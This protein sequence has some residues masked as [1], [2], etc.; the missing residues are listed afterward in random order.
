MVDS[1]STCP[2]SKKSSAA[3]VSDEFEIEHVFVVA[4]DFLESGQ[5]DWLSTKSGVFAG[6]SNRDA[7]DGFLTVSL[8]AERLDPRAC[9][10][11]RIG[12]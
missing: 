11:S 12:P 9:F 8:I 7:F 5:V 6:E 1:Q 4:E 3:L 2:D 10:I